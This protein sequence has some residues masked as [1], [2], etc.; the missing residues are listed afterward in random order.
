MEN[1]TAKIL[2]HLK[3]GKTLTPREALIEHECFRL[4]ARIHDLRGRGWPIETTMLDLG[5]RKH[6]AQYML[7]NDKEKWPE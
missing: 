7:V 4:A 1:Q 2:A 3:A 6:C 5:D